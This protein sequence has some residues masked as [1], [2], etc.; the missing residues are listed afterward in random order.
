VA[1]NPWCTV[2]F[3]SCNTSA[4]IQ[5]FISRCALK[6]ESIWKRTQTYLAQRPQDQMNRNPINPSM[7]PRFPAF[8]SPL[9]MINP[10]MLPQFPAFQPLP[11]PY[12]PQIFPNIYQNHQVRSITNLMPTRHQC[13]RFFNKRSTKK[14]FLWKFSRKPLQSLKHDEHLIK[15]NGEIR[16]LNF[17]RLSE[18]GNKEP[19]TNFIR[20]LQ[21]FSQNFKIQRSLWIS[22]NRLID[23]F[24]KIPE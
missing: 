22:L 24:F 19:R 18:F 5:L 11:P 3:I 10:P 16:E 17:S 15:W 8:H 20:F 1:K 4:T 23:H 21:L 9:P 12:Q 2:Q 14:L 7:I 13:N 6:I